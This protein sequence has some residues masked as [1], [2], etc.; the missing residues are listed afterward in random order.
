MSQS[1]WLCPCERQRR[2]HEQSF[3]IVYNNVHVFHMM[4]VHFCDKTFRMV[5][6]FLPC[7]LDLEVFKKNWTLVITLK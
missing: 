4:I 1:Q 7:D 2:L 5:L 3:S 6:Y